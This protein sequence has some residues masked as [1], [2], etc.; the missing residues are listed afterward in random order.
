MEFLFVDETSDTCQSLSPSREEGF[1]HTTA[2]IGH[3][4]LVAIVN[5]VNL[6]V[7]AFLTS[8]SPVRLAV[9]LRGVVLVVPITGR[10]DSSGK[11]QL[12]CCF[13]GLGRKSTKD[14]AAS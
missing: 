5:Q 6:G 1:A 4:W 13:V 14:G 8:T 12:E 11:S 2:S 3:W 10:L 9:K 7:Q